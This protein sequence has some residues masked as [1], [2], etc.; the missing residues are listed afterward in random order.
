MAQTL[1]TIKATLAAFGLQ[2]KHRFGQNFLHDANKLARIMQA[3][4]V[5]NDE[6][7]LE[8]GPG[9]G[10][11]SQA[12]LDAGARL[13]AV[14]I[15]ADL[16]PVLKPVFEPFPDRAALVLGD[17]LQSKRE[18]NPHVIAMIKHVQHAGKVDASSELLPFKLVANLPY[19]IAS[20]LLANL[21]TD[22]PAMKLAVVM[23]QS[24][25]A[26]RLAAGPGGKDFGP[27]GILI[28]AM[29]HVQRVDTLS[30]ECFWPRPT[31]ASAVVSLRRRDQPLTNDP[32]GLSTFLAKLFQSRRKQLGTSLG[33]KSIFPTGIDPSWRPEQLSIQQIITLQ[34]AGL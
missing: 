23:V 12:L 27:L 25:V 16:A 2:P 32:Q 31:I 17:V 15:D 24:E 11:L 26:D 29:C 30:P 21:V 8:V 7:I 1:S 13:V 4:E 5:K 34:Q 19:H 28:Q 6:T 14:E 10:V 9:T 20:P 22:Y 3:S 33:R 18:I